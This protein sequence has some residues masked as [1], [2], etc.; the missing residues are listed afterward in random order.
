VRD[1]QPSDGLALYQSV[2]R[3]LAGEITEVV[4]AGCYVREAN[5][6]T[7]LRIYALNMTARYM[8]KVG[9]FWIVY[10]GS[11]GYEAISPRAAFLDGYMPIEAPRTE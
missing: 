10:P 11:D 3:V 6:D 5:G 8:P 4:P 7:V 2:K 9:D 1:P